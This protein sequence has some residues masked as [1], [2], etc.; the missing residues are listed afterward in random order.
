MCI[1]FLLLLWV[2]YS[3]VTF[4]IFFFEELIIV[5]AADG[6]GGGGRPFGLGGIVAVVCD[7]DAGC[8]GSKISGRIV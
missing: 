8:D 4:G 2:A 1:A 6:G 5:I 7:C 3:S